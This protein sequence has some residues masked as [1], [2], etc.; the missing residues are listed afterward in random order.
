MYES[1]KTMGR[2]AVGLTEEFKVEVGLHQG[3]TLSPFLLAMV[4]DRLTDDLI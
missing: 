3:S 1:F 4:M 2:F